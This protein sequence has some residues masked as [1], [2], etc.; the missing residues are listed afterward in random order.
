MS[1]LQ[2]KINAPEN[3][4]DRI[5]EL[6]HQ[7]GAL[8]VTMEDAAS[9]PVYEPPPGTTPLWERTRVVGLFEEPVDSDTIIECIHRHIP[10]TG[11]LPFQVEP[12]EDRDW[13]RAW[14]KDFH[15]ARFGSSLWVCPSWLAPPVPEAVNILL[16]PGVAFGTGTHPTTALCLEWLDANAPRNLYVVDFG[17]GS[18]ILAIAAA[19]LG[20]KHVWAI[21]H[22]PQAV[23][24][25]LAN[26]QKN[27]VEDR[28]TAGKS[29][30][31]ADLKV[32]TLLANILAD[33]LTALAPAFAQLLR[34]GGTA[35]L[36]GILNRQV[37]QITNRYSSW[38]DV[39]KI[40][41][42]EDWASIE[43]ILKR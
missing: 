18:G 33:P 40:E 16:D 13:E 4:V 34:P 17:C 9:H 1:W 37:S 24:A 20:A 31:V 6:L 32:D 22:D 2:L 35:L 8:A 11:A 28:I 12:L 30:I 27:G 3:L 42:K 38:F 23:E 29:D 10:L 26:A 21:D 15:P 7:S 41:N 25:T 36:S 14:M 43:G 39:V 5:S 19:K